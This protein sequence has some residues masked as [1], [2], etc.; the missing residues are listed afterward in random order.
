[1]YDECL[2]CMNNIHKKCLLK[3]NHYYCYECLLKWIYISEKYKNI[4]AKCPICRDKINYINIFNNEYLHFL[5]FNNLNDYLIENNINQKKY[6]FI[7][8]FF[9]INNK[10]KLKVTDFSDKIGVKVNNIQNFKFD[11]NLKLKKGDIIIS[12]NYI[13]CIKSEFVINLFEYLYK[14][15]INEKIIILTIEKL[16]R[17]FLKIF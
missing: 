11:K 8:I 13:P 12:I 17:N 6:K 4:K 5:K 3:C 10:F 1:M 14:N 7:N 16:K 2:I 9:D 15:N